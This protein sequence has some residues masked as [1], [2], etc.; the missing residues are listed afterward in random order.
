MRI[1]IT[2]PLFPWDCLEDSPSLQTIHQFLE[3]VPDGLLLASLRQARGKGRNDYPVHVLCGT[4]WPTSAL[5]RSGR[6]SN[7]AVRPGTKAGPV[8]CR[9][10][11]TRASGTG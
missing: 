1:A 2:K 9:R 7:T 8:R 5:S 4:A 10:P 6:R 3:A 11:A